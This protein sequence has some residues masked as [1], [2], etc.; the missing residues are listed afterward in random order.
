MKYIALLTKRPLLYRSLE[1]LNIP[2]STVETIIVDA[3]RWQNAEKA[4]GRELIGVQV[5]FP[6]CS[7]KINADGHRI[8]T[9]E[10]EMY[11]TLM[12]RIR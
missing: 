11:R 9:R 6:L 10:H 1:R 7:H 12:S 4:F 8:E 2:L 5:D 3:T